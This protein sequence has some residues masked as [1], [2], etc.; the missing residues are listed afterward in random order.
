MCGGKEQHS[1]LDWNM[2]SWSNKLLYRQV[3]SHGDYNGAE[4]RTKRRKSDKNKE[5]G[6]AELDRCKQEMLEGE[7]RKSRYERDTIRLFK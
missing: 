6:N 4:E 2:N 5:E 7:T 3:Q 1:K